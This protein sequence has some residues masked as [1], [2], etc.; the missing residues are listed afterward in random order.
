MA[1][2]FKLTGGRPMARTGFA[3]TDSVSRES[4]CYYTDKLGR[5]W[6]A[7]GAWSLFRVRHKP[8]TQEP[9]P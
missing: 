2:I 3:F 7:T 1:W 4:V 6:L 5:N 8:S 9:S